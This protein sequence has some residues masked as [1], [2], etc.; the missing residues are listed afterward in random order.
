VDPVCQRLGEARYLR[1]DIIRPLEQTPGRRTNIFREGSRPIHPEDPTMVAEIRKP[2]LAVAA[3]TT[4]NYSVRDD[5]RPWTQEAP[6][7]HTRPY[8]FDVAT[9]FVTQDQRGRSPRAVVQERLDLTSTDSAGSDPDQH[10]P[11]TGNREG[12]IAQFELVPVRIDERLHAGK[13]TPSPLFDRSAHEVAP[14]GP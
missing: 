3:T 8:G 12:L 7:L 4:V 9:E 5:R 1:R 6:I 14:F 10:L 13:G 2:E 11:R